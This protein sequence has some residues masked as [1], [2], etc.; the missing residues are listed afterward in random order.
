MP[1]VSLR[2]GPVQPATVAAL[3]DATSDLGQVESARHAPEDAG[4]A[5][6]IADAIRI[7][8]LFPTVLMGH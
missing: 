3:S 6:G 2:P 5:G 4:S 1:H 8:L 7:N